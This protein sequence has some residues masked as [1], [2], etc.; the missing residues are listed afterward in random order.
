MLA[1]V[2]SSRA[3][4][5][6]PSLPLAPAV[7]G[8]LQGRAA[9]APGFAQSAHGRRILTTAAA[10]WHETLLRA[11]PA[12]P[13]AGLVWASER[14]AATAAER[15]DE[16]GDLCLELAQVLGRI[17]AAEEP[18]APE[19]P[20]PP[21]PAAARFAA[22]VQDAV[23]AGGAAGAPRDDGVGELL[24]APA[25]AFVCDET[26]RAFWAAARRVRAAP[27]PA[28]TEAP[29][30][31]PPASSAAAALFGPSVAPRKRPRRGGDGRVEGAAALPEY[32]N[33][34]PL[35][36]ALWGGALWSWGWNGSGRGK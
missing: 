31:A 10:V 6:P 5:A 26:C 36:C 23:R 33:V 4:A 15:A 25:G 12:T 7:H 17:A 9:A 13:A 19:P 24:A 30:P 11:P 1:T 18:P 16:V 35:G 14:L 2:S 3:G 34:A 8:P 32:R 29:P 21:R 22:A 28:K 20:Q 27:R